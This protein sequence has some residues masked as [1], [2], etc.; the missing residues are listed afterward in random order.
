MGDG[1]ADGVA[2]GV[3]VGDGDADGVADGVGDGAAD[4]VADGAA[5]G[6]GVGDGD[7]DG[8][9]DGVGVGDGVAD[10]AAD[11]VG[12][13]DGVGAAD[14]DADGVADGVGDGAADGVLPSSS[15]SS[16]SSP[17]GRPS[18][19]RDSCPERVQTSSSEPAALGTDITAT[20]NIVSSAHR[21]ARERDLSI[22]R[23]FPNNLKIKALRRFEGVGFLRIRRYCANFAA[24]RA[25]HLVNRWYRK[26]IPTA[27]TAST[28]THHSRS[29]SMPARP[30]PCR[31]IG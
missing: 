17:S 21:A 7:A 25:S 6:V 5:D 31:R 30:S 12:V 24:V 15:S 19:T 26:L 18:A 1:S 11:G 20:A 3:G 27:K 8:V 10:G 29:T 23:Q 2:D 22:C 13:G 16:S 28:P 4:G 9:A 14:G